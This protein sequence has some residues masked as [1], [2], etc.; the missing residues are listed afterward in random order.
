VKRKK[1]VEHLRTIQMISRS[2]APS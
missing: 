1:W 2:L